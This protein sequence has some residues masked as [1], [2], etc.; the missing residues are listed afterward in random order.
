MY[1]GHFRRGDNTLYAFTGQKYEKLEDRDI[2]SFICEILN[3]LEIGIVYQMNSVS[4]IFSRIMN[5]MN[6]P[7]FKPSRSMISMR[8]GVLDLD[9]MNFTKH[10]ERFMTRVYLEFDY[11]PADPCH[12]WKT[13]L[14][15]RVSVKVYRLDLCLDVS[16]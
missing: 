14:S 15:F 5:D 1:K 6:I 3:K 10:D 7:E 16:K 13:I 2:K 8:N 9:T 12:L 4:K 11:A